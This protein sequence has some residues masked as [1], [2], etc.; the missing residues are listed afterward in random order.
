MPPRREGKLLVLCKAA[1]RCA[2]FSTRQLSTNHASIVFRS[3]ASKE[4]DR[5]E[6]ANRRS[7]SGSIVSHAGLSSRSLISGLSRDDVERPGL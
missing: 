2:V 3:C 6:V 5:R 1:D 4:G 7:S